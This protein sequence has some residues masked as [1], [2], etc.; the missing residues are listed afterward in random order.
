MPS[1]NRYR[2]TLR[3]GKHASKSA[4]FIVQSAKYAGK[5][6]EKA[7][8]GLARWATID[9]TGTAKLLTDAPSMGFINTLSMIVVTAVTTLLGAVASVAVFVLLIT[10][11]IPLLLGF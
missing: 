5:Y 11:G 8:I 3:G 9:H 2:I 1:S 7:A 4:K 6:A 10:F